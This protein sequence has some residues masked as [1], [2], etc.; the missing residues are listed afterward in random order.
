MNPCDTDGLAL[1]LTWDPIPGPAVLGAVGFRNREQMAFQAL[2]RLCMW[3]R[4]EVEDRVRAPSRRCLDLSEKAFPEKGL[5]RT[6][7]VTLR[8]WPGTNRQLVIM[9]AH[10][11]DDKDTGP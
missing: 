7:S 8:L 5:E 9:R 1:S 4:R 3:G 11:S 10:S 6:D 2:G